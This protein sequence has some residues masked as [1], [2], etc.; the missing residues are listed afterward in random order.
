MAR[1]GSPLERP[2]EGQ[3][4]ERDDQ[5]DVVVLDLAGVRPGGD[6]VERELDAELLAALAQ[7]DQRADA[8]DADPSSDSLV[9]SPASAMS[10]K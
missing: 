10:D 8:I 6:H 1:P 5:R 2:H 7:I 9:S 4:D 3:E